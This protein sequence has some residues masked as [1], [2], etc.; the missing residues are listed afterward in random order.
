METSTTIEGMIRG[1]RIFVPN[2]QRA[3]SW[4]VEK[5]ISVFLENKPAN[6]KSQY[7]ALDVTPFV[8]LAFSETVG[9]QEQIYIVH[10][11][12]NQQHS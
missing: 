10:R 12:P 2:Y 7:A 3:Y 9:G 4:E 8:E 6:M 11:V 5:Q 1:N